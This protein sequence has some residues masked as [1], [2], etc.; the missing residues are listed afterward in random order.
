M[1]VVPT[2]PWPEERSV[3]R[4][5]I[6]NAIAKTLEW[7][8]PSFR[9]SLSGIEGGKPMDPRI[10]EDDDACYCTYPCSCRNILLNRR[11]RYARC[12]VVRRVKFR[13]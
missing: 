3:I 7:V 1:V 5:S 6:G 2:Q 11:K 13:C 8:R 10:R 12:R 9:V 4:Q